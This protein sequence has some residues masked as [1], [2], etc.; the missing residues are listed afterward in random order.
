MSAPIST[1]FNVEFDDDRVSLD[2]RPPGGEAWTQGFR[3]ADVERVCFKAEG[4]DL[5]DG[6]Y[7]FTSLRPESFV[8]PTDATG[9]PELW[10]EIIRRGHFD[11]TLAISAACADTG[12]F[13][14]PPS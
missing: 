2:V 10:A 9:G 3:W 11:A 4:L 6:I 13:C 5:S 7:V 1:W 8:I 14:W 12:T